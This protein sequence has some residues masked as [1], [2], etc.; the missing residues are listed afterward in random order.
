M[1]VSGQPNSAAL[2]V[3][4]GEEPAVHL[5]QG[6]SL[7]LAGTDCRVRLLDVDS[8]SGHVFELRCE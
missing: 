7:P 5:G 4:V 1:T 3:N 2:Y 6:R 8:P